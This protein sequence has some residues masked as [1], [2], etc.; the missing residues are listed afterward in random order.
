[1][2]NVNAWLS[3]RLLG[4]SNSEEQSDSLKRRPDPFGLNQSHGARTRE[5]ENED[6]GQDRQA[7]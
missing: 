5:E 3:Q 4:P 6:W 1:M 7:G 2:G